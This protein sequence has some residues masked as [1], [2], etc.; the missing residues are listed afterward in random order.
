MGCLASLEF[1]ELY[2]SILVA[3]Q[4]IITESGTH[5]G[6]VMFI[7]ADSLETETRAGA[8]AAVVHDAEEEVDA[9]QAEAFRV[10]ESFVFGMLRNFGSLP[11]DRIHNMLKMFVT[12]HACEFGP[13]S[14]LLWRE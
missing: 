5:D 12:D 4:G 7:S 9:A 11:L 13:A 8:G 2:P 1:V 3:P 10:Y 6:S 14:T